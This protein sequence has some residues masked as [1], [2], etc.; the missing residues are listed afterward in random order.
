MV[1]AR[2]A[3]PP[4]A[5][6]FSGAKHKRGYKNT[7]TAPSAYGTAGQPNAQQ[8]GEAARK[9]QEAEAMVTEVSGEADFRR[10]IGVKGKLVVVSP[11][12][13][14]STWCVCSFSRNLDTA[15]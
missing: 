14:L 10:Q 4:G 9:A 11:T 13:S 12:G 15:T 6:G 1:P 2:P 5:W 3:A 8:A 7:F